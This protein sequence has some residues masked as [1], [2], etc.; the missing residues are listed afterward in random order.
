MLMAFFSYE[1]YQ[2]IY[3][4]NVELKQDSVY[5]HIATGSN[6]LQLL[7]SI[8]PHLKDTASFIWLAKL[9][10]YWPHIKSGRYKIENKWN[11][12]QLINHLRAGKQAP[13]NLILNNIKFKADLAEFFGE[14][15]EAPADS[16]LELFNS[17]RRLAKYALE[18]QTVLSVFRPNTYQFYWNTSAQASLERMILEN[19]K[20]W[21]ERKDKLQQ[22]GLSQLELISLASIVESETAKVDEMPVVAGLYLNRLKQ[23][24]KL[25]SDPTVIY[26]IQ[27]D[28]PDTVIRRVFFR[29][30]VYDSPYNTYLY[31]GLPP[32]PI[33]IPNA[34]AIDAVLNAE[35]HRYIFMCA[36]PEK[37]GYQSFATSL[38]GHNRNRD[39]YIR[40]VRAL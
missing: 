18:P 3:S 4:R 2:D 25:Q 6:G 16:F 17:E 9:K 22:S 19:D 33:R 14:Q 40:W 10:N 30:L 5:I 24:I 39:K 31:K 32:G 13:I 8:E 28:Y 1:Y 27:Q 34:K 15:L 38:K 12:N 20:F 7:D 26:S 11:N 21:S 23:G 36:N 35:K 29:D 37:P